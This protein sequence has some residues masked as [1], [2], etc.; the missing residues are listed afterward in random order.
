MMK[1]PL[2]ERCPFLPELHP[3]H[4]NFHHRYHDLYDRYH[5][6]Y[7]PHHNFHHRYHELYD[8]YRELYGSRGGDVHAMMRFSGQVE[9]ETHE[10]MDV[11]SFVPL[12]DF[13]MGVPY[14]VC[15]DKPK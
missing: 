3:R 9:I 8:R 13:V 14:S 6:L 7:D 11:P 15:Q 10:R 2:M 4:H 5:Q 12:P 1:A